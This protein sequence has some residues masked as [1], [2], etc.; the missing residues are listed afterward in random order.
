M[1]LW[2]VSLISAILVTGCAT[3]QKVIWDKPGGTLEDFRRDNYE[4]V[5]Q[6]RVSWSGG[7]TGSVGLVIMAGAQAQAQ[8]QA[9]DLYRMCMEAGGWTGHVQ[10]EGEEGIR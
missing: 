1:K 8:K 2:V 6:S 4:C 5:Q 9:N 10:Q 7:G 3:P